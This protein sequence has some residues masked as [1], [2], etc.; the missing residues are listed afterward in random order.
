[1][2]NSFSSAS[3]GNQEGSSN[4]MIQSIVPSSRTRA[5]A[6]NLLNHPRIFSLPPTNQPNMQFEINM[7]GNMTDMVP[8][9]R[10]SV[11]AALNGIGIRPRFVSLPSEACQNSIVISEVPAL[12]WSFILVIFGYCILILFN[13]HSKLFDSN[14]GWAGRSLLTLKID[15]LRTKVGCPHDYY[16]SVIPFDQPIVIS[17]RTMLGTHAL[18][19][20][21]IT[22]L[23]ENFNHADP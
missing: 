10:N 17:V 22:F 15:E 14:V 2:T 23:M 8:A 4:A 6:S 21:I 1:M 7:M 12:D 13:I 3:G 19:N 11:E 16:Y 18:R 5:G 20:S 9:F